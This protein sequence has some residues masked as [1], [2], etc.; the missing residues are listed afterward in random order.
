MLGYSSFAISAVSNAI[1]LLNSGKGVEAIEILKAD[2]AAAEGDQ[3]LL[4][5]Y[6][7]ADACMLLDDEYCLTQIYASS[8]K[9]MGEY[10][11]RYD[12]K[13]KNQ[14]NAWRTI[15]DTNSAIYFYASLNALDE[16]NFGVAL[17]YEDKAFVGNPY[18]SHGGL[19]LVGKAAIAAYMGKQAY[20]EQQMRRAR[21]LI[22]NKDPGTIQAQTNLAFL[23]ETSLFYLNDSRDIKRWFEANSSVFR[24]SGKDASLYLNPYVYQRLALVLYNSGVLDSKRQKMLVEDI[25]QRFSFLQMADQS[26]L[27]RKKEEFY[28]FLAFDSVR[29]NPDLS[30]N[31][32]QELNK[33]KSN[34]F[35]SMGVKAYLSIESGSPNMEELTTM[36]QKFNANYKNLGSATQINLSPTKAILESLVAKAEK[37]TDREILYLESYVD[38]M[39]D[40]FSK[41]GFRVGDNNPI[42]TNPAITV[43]WYVLNRLK[44]IKPTSEKRVN[45]GLL[46]LQSVNS[47][48]FGDEESSYSILSKAKNDIEVEQVLNFITIKERYGN[49]VSRA[50]KNSSEG[51]IKNQNI[52]KFEDKLVVP[53]ESS[54]FLLDMFSKSNE[55]LEE[56]RSQ[57]N[58][59]FILDYKEVSKKLADDEIAIL[60][61]SN[62]QLS[63]YVIISKN[64]A[65]LK[66]IDADDISFLKAR[67]ILTS[68][69]IAEKSQAELKASSLVVSRTIFDGVQL[70]GKSKI[71]LINGPTLAGIPYTL[72]SNPK[73]GWLIK[74]FKVRAFHAAPQFL[75][76]QQLLNDYSP[77]YSY[78]GFA[79]PL[80]RGEDET[81]SVKNI[82]SLIRGATVRKITSL[83][84]LPET[85]I[86]VKDFAKSLGG[87]SQIYT[88]KRATIENLFQTNLNE[89]EVLGFATHG[90][91]VGEL[92]GVESPSLVLTPHN[93]SGLVT[94]EIL[95]SLHGAPKVVILSTCNSKTTRVSLDQSE[96]TSLATSF[97]LKGTKSVIASYW[98][99]NSD[100]TS[101][102]MS[103]IAKYMGKGLSYGDAL[104]K[105]QLDLIESPR[106]SHPAI[107]AAFVG[108]G[109]FSNKK[110]AHLKG[111]KKSFDNFLIDSA[112]TT[113]GD[114]LLTSHKISTPNP[115]VIDFDD[116]FIPANLKY[117]SEL[118]PLSVKAT[119]SSGKI[120]FGVHI[121]S[122]YEIFSNASNGNS[123]LK[124]CSFPISVDWYVKRFLVA[125]DLAYVLL[126]R[127]KGA[128][129]EPALASVN[130]T[131]CEVR[132]SIL[133]SALYSNQEDVGI[134]LLK[135]KNKILF[136][137]NGKLKEPLKFP[138]YVDE[139]NFPRN[140]Q[141]QNKFE[142]YVFD[143]NF[144]LLNSGSEV[145][146]RLP[147]NSYNTREWIHGIYTNECTYENQ[148]KKINTSW[149]QE[150]FLF[151][152]GTGTLI[153]PG[154]SDDERLIGKNFTQVMGWSSDDSGDLIY[155]DGSPG[156]TAVL[157][158][159]RA[160]L[161]LSDQAK[162]V[163]INSE[164]SQ[165]VFQKS[166]KNWLRVSSSSE[167]STAYPLGFR[168]EILFACNKYNASNPKDSSSY[169]FKANLN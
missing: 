85:E 20:A 65:T 21:A 26:R 92:D 79:N 114:V 110:E 123:P 156:I 50:Y 57:K 54:S 154:L 23:Q 168:R 130:L 107:W 71:S 99:V 133:S 9:D 56:I 3:K 76:R 52:A 40:F 4:A 33:L 83:P 140:C 148:P 60:S 136:Y 66:V 15:W 124:L 115:D 29:K 144:Q 51:L 138:A 103:S 77:T 6:A 126:S 131:S 63:I 146:L 41:K 163:A 37:N 64:H 169:L 80:L 67:E 45:L 134:Q 97:S 152:D 89:V 91:M 109:D 127:E 121:N 102:L 69:D 68:S 13:D 117:F 100:G 147:E 36:L 125:E 94:S 44:Q 98:A 86:E 55:Q 128:L 166:T 42:Q 43:Q 135:Q 31:P 5:V 160:A 48:Q 139:L 32:I 78:V 88:G 2:V 105:A 82:A 129:S 49:Y 159:S 149:F 143:N 165:Y 158:A 58:D 162:Q 70:N 113:G 61:A 132:T 34:S 38:S 167:C 10:L 157:F 72:L 73:G 96:I 120:Y 137:L 119:E 87:K 28:A 12:P 118:N 112:L 7:L 22:L 8:W 150:K 155:V 108:V 19:R 18:S 74:D 27:Y 24:E 75:S 14:I 153:R 39:L 101:T 141:F 90:V 104:N 95:F 17:S 1:E 122:S 142:Y 25:H 164:Y 35:A 145:N 16:K 46:M 81:A 59:S 30:F 11:N 116:K 151:H 62:D 161:S 111:Q 84:E 53:A 106:Y 47:S 93:D